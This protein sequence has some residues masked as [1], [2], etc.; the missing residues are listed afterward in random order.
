MIKSIGLRES[1]F[2]KLVLTVTED[3]DWGYDCD[4]IPNSLS[5]IRTRDA[6]PLDMVEIVSKKVEW[7]F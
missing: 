6:L 7:K 5:K 1:V 3:Y 4:G 2:G